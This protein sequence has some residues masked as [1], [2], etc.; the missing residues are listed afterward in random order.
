M[1]LKL[2]NSGLILSSMF[3]YLEWGGGNS[4]FLF[5]GEVEV[6]SK[7][8][9][10]PWSVIHP[11]TLMPL[12]SQL[13]LLITLFQKKPSRWLTLAGIAC[14]ALLLVFIFLIGILGLNLKMATSAVPFI[15]LAML[16]IRELLGKPRFLK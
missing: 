9:A 11:F 15:A 14:V 10:D 3:G 6:L 8:L 12:A 16:T 1:R 13:D 2:L 5:K 4:M 7:L